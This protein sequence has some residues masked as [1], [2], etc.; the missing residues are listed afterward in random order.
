MVKQYDTWV[1]GDEAYIQLKSGP[2]DSTLTFR[3]RGL[4]SAWSLLS[5]GSRDLDFH[6]PPG[7]LLEDLRYVLNGL[8]YIIL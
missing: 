4:I 5:T 7:R 8:E 3:R 1:A 6:Y 2:V